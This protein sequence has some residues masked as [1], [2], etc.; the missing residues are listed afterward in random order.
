MLKKISEIKNFYLNSPSKTEY[1]NK[2]IEI[3]SH[4]DFSKFYI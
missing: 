2:L 4:S 3:M 1:Q